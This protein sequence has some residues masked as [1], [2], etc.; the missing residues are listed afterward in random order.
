VGA[1]SEHFN[2]ARF[3]EQVQYGVLLVPAADSLDT[4]Q[5]IP[6]AVLADQLGI[7]AEDV[8]DERLPAAS[9]GLRARW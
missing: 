4:R 8:F 3:A 6:A 9:V 5:A 7:L 1:L 2:S